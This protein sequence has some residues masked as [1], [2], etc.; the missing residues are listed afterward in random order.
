MQVCRQA[1][2][3]VA[4]VSMQIAMPSSAHLLLDWPSL[5]QAGVGLVDSCAFKPV[6]PLKACGYALDPYDDTFAQRSQG[7]Y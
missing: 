1:L 5:F 7:V 2:T 3:R 6:P 4:Q